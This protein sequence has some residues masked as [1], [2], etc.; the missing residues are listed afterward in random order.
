MRKHVRIVVLVVTLF[1]IIAAVGLSAAGKIANN[2][3]QNQTDKAPAADSTSAVSASASQSGELAASDAFAS[4]PADTKSNTTETVPPSALENAADTGTNK[5]E[6]TVMIDITMKDGGV[7]RLELDSEAAPLTVA[8][9]VA[10]VEDEFYDGLIFHRIIPNFMVQGGDP[11][12]SGMGGSD[13]QIK[14][15]FASNG[16]ENPISHARGVISMARSQDKNSASSQ[17]FITNGDAQFLDGDYAAFGRVV[18]G[19]DVIDRISAVKTGA[20]DR[21][22]EDVVIE[23]IRVVATDEAS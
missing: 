1:T 22:E 14:G 19:M 2:N 10:L 6:N 21:P 20:Q 9:F 3:T 15:E 16:W 12:G 11:E 8:N 7:I 18:E 17:F 4:A 5:K 13:A 23:T